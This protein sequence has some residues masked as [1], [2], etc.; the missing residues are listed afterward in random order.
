MEEEKDETE[1]PLLIKKREETEA[2]ELGLGRKVW[3]ESKKLWR[4]VGPAIFLRIATYSM[5]MVSQAFV[6][7]LGDLELASMSIANTFSGFNFGLLLGMAS[8]LETLCGQ[9]Y[10]AKKHHLLGVYL[11]RSW[12]VLFGCAVLL[13][14]MY[15]FAT[16]FL[17]LVG[18]PPELARQAGFV[19]V[20]FIPTHFAFA[21]LFPLNRFLQ[22]QLKNSVTAVTS[23]FTLTVH[24]LLSWLVVFKWEYGLLGATV[25][26][27]FSWWLLV[28]CQFAYVA[29]GGCPLTW[30]GFSMEAFLDL[31]EFVKLSAA[32]GVMLCLENWYYRVLILL[33]GNLENAAI[34]V[35]AISICMNINNWEMMIPLA[36]FAGTGVRVAN[37]LGGG[38]SRGAK[39]ATIV[40]VVTS[41]MIGIM[42][43]CIIMVFH[44]KFALIFS[45]S[46]VV[47]IAVDKLSPIL[48]VTILLNSVQPILSG[49]AVGA[50][51]QATV[52]YVNIGTYYIIG[53]PIGILLGWIFHLGVPG[54]WAGM[55]GGTVVQTIVLTYI[56]LRCDWDKEALKASERVEKWT[57]SRRE[58]T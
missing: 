32:S 12:L 5:N 44:D 20:W 37:E 9:A 50:G 13:L 57:I 2:S 30:K 23:G 11:Q 21:F 53:I 17:E 31:W 4:I 33:T 15:V 40:S 45:S 42:F 54:I 52:A 39:F 46:Q 35:D 51:W 28:L 27:G 24:I 43:C 1:V 18:E 25:T 3:N 56:T 47:L 58:N 26:L 29:C 49:V 55:I 6:G 38:N 14:P 34:A 16:P 8:A 48:A 10:G 19:C 7:H 22:S 36:F 41:S